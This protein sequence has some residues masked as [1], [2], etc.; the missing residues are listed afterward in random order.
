M[1]PDSTQLHQ[2]RK[3]LHLAART[4]KCVSRGDHITPML[5]DLKWCPVELR[6]IH[7]VVCLVDKALRG[8]APGYLRDELQVYTPRRALRSST[9]SHITLEVQRTNKKVGDGAFNSAGP[10]AWNSLPQHLREYGKFSPRSFSDA[11]LEQF[12]SL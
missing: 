12:L 4:V 3:V 8:L 1:P 11:V 10:R 2:L 5:Q 6:P 7:K 9:T